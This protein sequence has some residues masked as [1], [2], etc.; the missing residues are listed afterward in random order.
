MPQKQD[1]SGTSG[2]QRQP[3][4]LIHETSP[5][6]QQHAWNPVDWY[7]WGDEALEKARQENRMIFLSIGYSSCHWCHVMERES[8]EDEQVARIL[9]KHFVNI[10]VDR[11]ER[12]DVDAL[13]MEALQMMTG[14]GGWPLN[15]WLTPGQVPVFAG[16]YFPPQDYHGRPG[17]TSVIMKLASVYEQQPDKV[18]KQAEEMQT[19]LKNDIYDRLD[20]AP[21]S[22]EQLEKAVERYSAAYDEDYGGFSDAP[23]FPTAMGIG[24][25]LR[26]SRRPGSEKARDM[27][28]HSLEAMIKGGIYDQAGGGFHRYSTDRKWLV[29]HFEKML[30]D[31]ALLLPVLAEAAVITGN[32]LFADTARETLAFLNREMRHPDGAYYSALDAD[33]DGVEGKF[34]TYT[35]SEL[36]SVLDED[37]LNLV[38]EHYGV[39]PE[40]NWEGVSILHRS[41]PLSDIAGRNNTT[42]E[43]LRAKL[44][45]AKEKLLRYRNQRTRPGL[46]DKIITSWNA[47]MLIALCRCS[48]L[49]D[50]PSDDAV[51]LGSFLSGRVVRGNMVYRIVDKD[52]N[53]RQPGFLDDYALLCEAFSHLFEL[54]GEPRWL[55]LS[56]RLARQLKEQFYDENK[57]AFDFSAQD[58][59]D[60]ISGT[61]DIFDNAVPGGN[62][63]AI[64]ALY[65]TGQLAGVPEWTRLAVAA[66]EPLAEIAGEHAPAF[67]YLLQVMHRHRHPGFEIIIVPAST[68]KKSDEKSDGSG[69]VGG[70]AAFGDTTGKMVH[71]WRDNFDPGSYLVILQEKDAEGK[72]KKQTKDPS[73][74]KSSPAEPDANGDLAQT[75]FF[76]L[77]DDKK[78]R[79]GKTTA[80]ICRDFQCRKPVNTPEEFEE[81]LSDT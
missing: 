53:V 59:S 74:P 30:Y 22:V 57:N 32:P 56:V 66:T 47:M 37:E 24:F 15:V 19:A 4:R 7:P 58:R 43:M 64:S 13:Y 6:L 14:Q 36:Q 23:K 21:V 9:N 79:N 65:R 11:E 35:Y 17:F 3:N 16:T 76:S 10:K 41:T 70:P 25:L 8:F 71:L 50:H 67:G 12:P 62:S 51:A 80:Y 46:D 1:N 31:N 72:I 48:R 45:K 42:V 33:T 29:P 39:T 73:R 78:L 27:A 40:G 52:D 55:A 26:Q 60:L 20:P 61:R 68:D 28:V 18:R 2:P 81:Q 38:S 49:I 77:Y 75:G 34:Y 54:T 63:A 69:T 44:E 5:Y